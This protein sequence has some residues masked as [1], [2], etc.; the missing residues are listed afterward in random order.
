MRTKLKFVAA[1]MEGQELSTGMGG[2][3]PKYL[4]IADELRREIRAGIHKPGDRMPAETTLVDRFRVSLP[5]IRQALGVLRAEGLVES[6]QGIGTF[7]KEDRRLQRRS[8]HRYGRARSDRQLLTSQFRHDIVFAGQEPA[9]DYVAEI[10]SIEPSTPVVVRRRVLHDK[11]TDRV[12]EI[13]ASYIPTEFSAGTFLEK[14]QVVPKAL[15]LCVED[16]SGKRYCYARDRWVSRSATPDE[17]SVL[18]LPPGGQVIHVVH[19]AEAD[20]GTVL[21]VS[22][23]IWPADRITV[24]DEYPITPDAEDPTAPSDI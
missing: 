6:R 9:P 1:E 2:F 23:S 7:V 21:E 5:T 3:A 8:R 12:E 13:G 17:A 24:I 18:E 20:D 16:L 14:P 11:Q 10:M 22:E 15:F 19:A 4:R